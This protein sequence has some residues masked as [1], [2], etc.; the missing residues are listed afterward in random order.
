MSEENKPVTETEDDATV[1]QDDP[2]ATEEKQDADIVAQVAKMLDQPGDE[3]EKPADT[4]EGESENP[5]EAETPKDE[6][7]EPMS[8]AIQDRV[9]AAGMSK[10]LA[11]RLHQSGQLEETLA[12]FDR[13]LIE[14]FQSKETETRAP[15]RREEKPPKEEPKAEDP[16]ELPDLD[17]DVYDEELVKRDAHHKRRI[18]ALEAQLAELVEERQHQFDVRFD[19]MVDGMGYEQLFGKGESVADDKQ[20]NRE[21]LFRAYC[22]V[23]QLY[24]AD[25]HECDVRWAERATAAMFPEEVF[26]QAQRQTVDRLRDAEGKFLTSSKPKGAPPAKDATDEE[27]HDQLVSDVTS[28]LKKQGVQMSGV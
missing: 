26:K 4:G 27:V 2:V 20:A 19:K 11:E 7:P 21:T 3:P 28:Y 23:C 8:Q 9:E 24:D 5:S 14:R 1:V 18:D 13:T 22:K 12:A 17:P 6:T 10:D 16:D 25:P 15:K